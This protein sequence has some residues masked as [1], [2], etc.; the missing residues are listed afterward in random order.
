MKIQDSVVFVTGG[1]RGLGKALVEEVLARGAAKVY[2][3]ARDPRTISNPNVVPL[4]LELT[5]PAS[6]AAATAQA[7]DVNL[8]INNAGVLLGADYLNGDLD[9]IRREIEINFYGPLQVTRALAPRLIANGGH[10][11]NIHTALSWYATLGAYAASKAAL[12]SMTNGLRQDLH[13]HGVGV[14]GLHVG[15][16]DTEPAARWAPPTDPKTTPTE[17][18]RQAIDGVEAGRHEVLV[19]DWTRMV[20]NGLAAEITTLYPHVAVN[21]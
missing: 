7:P 6:V 10:L 3:T 13:P 18:A 12:W 21:G 9:E 2:A 16:I 17:V 8:L 11:L 5:D 4:T 1:S 15:W 19:D 20:K 14:T